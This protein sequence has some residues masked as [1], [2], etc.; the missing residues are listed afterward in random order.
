MPRLGPCLLIACTGL[1]A[2]QAATRAPDLAPLAD[3]P[4]VVAAAADLD[5]AGA[6]NCLGKLRLLHEA[7]E[8]GRLGASNVPFAILLGGADMEQDWLDATPNAVSGAPPLEI[9]SSPALVPSDVPCLIQI[10]PAREQEAEHRVVGREEVA[11]VYQS[12]VRTVKNPDYDAAE[13]RLRKA[14]RA[15]RSG[16]DVGL[17]QVG[18][19]LLDLAGL[20]LGGALSGLQRFT[21]A[22]ELEEAMV[23]L[24]ATPRMREQPVLRPYRYRRTLV[25]AARKATI[26]VT[27]IDRV[28][29]RQ[30]MTELRQHEL[31]EIAL[32]DGLDPRDP[33]YEKLKASSMTPFELRRWKQEPP[34]LPWAGIVSAFLDQPPPVTRLAQAPASPGPRSAAPS[35]A[36]REA[37]LQAVAAA[38]PEPPADPAS[39]PSALAAAAD[40]RAELHAAKDEA[41][42]RLASV[43]R[44]QAGERQ[45]AGFYV[46]RNLLLTSKDAVGDEMVVDVVAE[47]RP[48][49]G[50]VIRSDPARGLALV[51]VGRPGRPLTLQPLPVRVGERAE[52]LILD[53]KGEPTLRVG[54]LVGQG[55]AQPGTESSDQRGPIY[56]NGQVI[57]L[58]EAQNGRLHLTVTAAELLAF[59]KEAPETL[60]AAASAR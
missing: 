22:Q 21:R 33:D 54:T 38:R 10:G 44:I 31:R 1:A 41:D 55:T 30:W 13:A 37:A 32:V 48:A 15:A 17:I 29:G 43:V 27:L 6:G 34:P 59:L 42:P 51:H 35:R 46:G 20:L 39:D 9:Y 45:G 14:E 4:A 23:A 36:R 56:W 40:W 28:S 5:W 8:E 50:L 11:S 19:P 25:R 53:A 60:P 58:G 7:A 49:L 3:R 47:G 18:D 16:Y 52:A 26:P 2:C 57:G 24:A 12:G